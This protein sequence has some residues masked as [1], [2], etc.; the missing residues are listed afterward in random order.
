MGEFKLLNQKIVNGFLGLI[1]PVEKFLVAQKVHPH[2]IT[3]A[4]LIFSIVAA[5]LFT[6]GSFLLGGI[7][8]ILTGVCDI[9][10]GRLARATNKTSKYGALIDS[11]IDRYSEVIIFLGIATYFRSENSY[12]HALII[13]AIAGSFLVSYTRAR[14]EGLGID[15]KIGILQRPERM[16][17][18]AAGGILGEI[19]Y[20]DHFMM[21]FFLWVIA[22]LANVTVIQRILYIRN[23]LRSQQA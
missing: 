18:L 20:T 17:F 21:I 12:V 3:A 13:L 9:L 15:C 2:L 19:P 8:V 5:Y 1:E 7:F 16:T 22:I 10:D 23:Q 4:G 6:E 11:T 14:A